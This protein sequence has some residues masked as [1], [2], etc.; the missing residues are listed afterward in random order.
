VLGR[1]ERGLEVGYRLVVTEFL[2]HGAFI[3]TILPEVHAIE[4]KRD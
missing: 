2:G 3:A 1:P 4:P